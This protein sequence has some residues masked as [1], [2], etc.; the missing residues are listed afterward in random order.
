MQ[1]T[2]SYIFIMVFHFDTTRPP[3][4]LE[5]QVSDLQGACIS[6]LFTSLVP[7]QGGWFANHALQ[8][9]CAVR[10]SVAGVRERTVRSTRAAEAVAELGSFSREEHL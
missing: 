8:R 5:P 9:L 10:S 2:V 4:E 3:E 7:R 1:R 6:Q